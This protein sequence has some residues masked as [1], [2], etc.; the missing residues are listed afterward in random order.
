MDP[1]IPADLRVCA[2]C[3][4]VADHV[5]GKGWLHVADA[6]SDAG[7]DHLVIPVRPDEIHTI[8]HCDFCNALHPAF[9][10]PVRDFLYPGSARL[11]F[12]DGDTGRSGSSG[13]WSAC[14]DCARL[15]ERN[16]W[17]GILRRV[18]ASR[19]EARHPEVQEGLRRLYRQVRANVTG[20]VRPLEWP[21]PRGEAS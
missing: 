9:M 19:A 11:V 6:I 17:N 12:P 18:T 13:G 8:G 15:L 7:Q 1:D 21:K 20:A 4:R 5:H 16:E 2:V 14:T 3:G 10:L